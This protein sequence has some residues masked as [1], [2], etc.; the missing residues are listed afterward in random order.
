MTTK[1][2][3][4]LLF[5]SAVFTVNI[6]GARYTETYTVHS[7]EIYSGYI[8]RTVKLKNY[9]LPEVSLSSVHFSKVA[10][11]P[12]GVSPAAP[13]QMIISLGKERKQP[14]AVIKIP[15]Y[16]TDINGNIQQ[17]TDFS[18]TIDEAEVQTAGVPAARPTAD[19]T[20]SVLSTGTWYKI[21]ITKTGFHKIDASVITS[22]GLDPLKVNP[23]NVR[24]YGNGGRMLSEANYV[25]RPADLRENATLLQDDGNGAFNAG[26]Y[27]VFYGAGPTGWD[28]DSANDRFAHL[29]NLYSDTAYYFITLDKGPGLR[30]A[31]EPA[32]GT[33]N[34][35][36][37][38][39]SY[40]DVHDIDL[41]NP[42]G[43]G[44]MWYGE[45]FNPLAGNLTQ[46]FNFDFGAPSSA[47]RCSVSVACT[48]QTG[49]AFAITAN[50]G[51][52]GSLQFSKGTGDNTQVLINKGEWEVAGTP[53]GVLVGIKFAAVGNS[54]GYLNFIEI[55]A[56]RPLSMWGDQMSFRD[57]HSYGAGKV[58]S[59]M[60]QGAGGN[61]RV[62]DVTDPQVPVALNGTLAGSTYTF[63][64]DAS[65]LREFAAMNSLNLF[66]PVFSGMVR[67]QNLHASGQ[68][69]DIIV[70]HPDFLPYA[71]QLADYHSAHDN[72][73]VLVVT[74]QQ[75]YNEFSSGAQDIS[76]IRDFVKMFY[77]RAGTDES[78]M[79]QYLTLFGAASYDYKD[80]LPNNSNFVPVFESAESSY[81]LAAVLTDDFYG[82]LDDN[83][84]IENTTLLNVLDIGI[85][86][87][88]ARSV[89]D[90]ASLVNKII[91]YRSPETLGPW[92]IASTLVADNNDGAGNHMQDE[93]E[94][95]QHITATTHNLYNHSKI[96]LDAIPTIST[97]AGPRAPNA[98]AAITDRVYKGTMLINYSGHGNTQV[99]ASE[100]I[101]TPDDFNKWSNEHM[102]PFMITA[103]CDYGQFDHPQYVS[104]GEQLVLHKGGGVICMLTTTA[105]VY[106]VYNN[107]LNALVLKTQ[108]AQKA[109]GK[110]HSFG[111]A[112]RIGKNATYATSV[113]ANELANY[114]K[115]SLLGDPALT[116][117]F[118]EHF[119]DVD[120]VIDVATSDVAD[121]IKALGAYRITGRV[122]DNNGN[123]LTGFNGV[124]S[125]SLFDKPRTVSTITAVNKTFQLQDNLVYKGK[126]SVTNGLY[127][128]TFIAPKDI[129]YYYGTAK[130]S[131]YAHNGV[132]DAAGADTSITVGGFSDNP[133]ISDVPPIVRPYI[134]DSL[135]QDGGI[136]GT[137]TS[138]FVSLYSETGINVSGNKLGHDLTAVL[139]DNVE[140]PY[141]L[142]DY[143]ETA[144]NTYQ[145]GY[146]NFPVNGLS[147]G[148]HTL[149]VK[150]WDVN[151]NSGE[152]SVNF[153]VMDGKVMAI[154]NLGNY[155]NPF[156]NTTHFVFEHNH[157]DEEI[158][159]KINIYS[160]GGS[161][162]KSIQQQF[163]PSGS[164]T[165]DLTWDGTDN[166]GARLPSGMYVYRIMLTT[167][168]GYR[169][170]AYQKLVIVR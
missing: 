63:T 131:N 48:G 17:V 153:V 53:S 18:L 88:P 35:S 41:V 27:V 70:T 84:Y 122:R 60:L 114:R 80:R 98:S 31:T 3:A 38:D 109:D 66:T 51:Q 101:L 82:F 112:S 75:I 59:Y 116:P 37:T 6:A 106:A 83:E 34:V 92:R 40:Y 135:F 139:D 118:P 86:R 108:L 91:R 23:A 168:K 126:V 94:M 124:L 143:Y 32:D 162:V 73:R 11:L 12:P 9:A 67:N 110:W 29:K 152:G 96:Y 55:N 57:L 36:V 103:T 120:S 8:V 10:S 58:A 93:E 132:T 117:N 151:N 46:T 123:T 26:D 130:I 1:I 42:V 155:P 115:F 105:A 97:P 99:W 129:N 163:T 49:N 65:T 62:W 24:V 167:E 127:S 170:T 156:S 160:S 13:Q 157:P 169:S 161:L 77:D 142:N 2:P 134:N 154:E 14:L 5:L 16:S 33:G 61:T 4:L 149:R 102:L 107:P 81:D 87:L 89:D 90:A 21:G 72:L 74:P 68:V 71:Q 44:K 111:E 125:V 47:V 150:A 25:P 104:A 119:V 15:A 39:Y 159:V 56:R 76:A 78:Q 144:P 141:I 138:L 148:R 50:G 164:R 95:G 30:V 85:G 64:R 128:Y 136:T 20:S 19:V 166:S 113:N 69:D 7:N 52:I 43:F 146:V 100:R 137:N 121:T 165:A 140:Q 22:M 79:P 158:D 147:D 45:Q 28:A 133:V 54:V 145:R